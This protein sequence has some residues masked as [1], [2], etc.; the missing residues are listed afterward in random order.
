[1]RI[2]Q[3]QNCVQ[4]PS[5]IPLIKPNYPEEETSLIEKLDK[6]LFPEDPIRDYCEKL[7]CD[8]ENKYGKILKEFDRLIKKGE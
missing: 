4:A 5:F 6:I 8:I 2:M 1:M 3:M 7:I